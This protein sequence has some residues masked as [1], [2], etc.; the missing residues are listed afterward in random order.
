MSSK[1][2][3]MK[4][5]SDT[6]AKVK[7]LKSVIVKKTDKDTKKEYFVAPIA[8]SDLLSLIDIADLQYIRI[9]NSKEG[10]PQIVAGG[11]ATLEGI[12][13]QVS[14]SLTQCKE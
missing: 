13:Y 1:F 7:G 14:I 3:D 10:K 4:V 11:K 2:E 8:K 12:K 6:V 5:A 9:A